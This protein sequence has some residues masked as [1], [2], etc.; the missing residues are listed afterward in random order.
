MPYYL[1]GHRAA[2][3]SSVVGHSPG[4]VI[5]LLLDGGDVDAEGGLERMSHVQVRPVDQ[6]TELSAGNVVPRREV[7]KDVLRECHGPGL[8]KPSPRLVLDRLHL[9]RR[10]DQVDTSLSVQKEQF[11]QPGVI[12][13]L[14]FECV[15]DLFENLLF[16]EC[17][18]HVEF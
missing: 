17:E 1:S 12:A 3:F 14:T 13:V 5:A 8:H 16:F 9:V 15:L 7:R 11:L 2:S 6:L 4:H 18:R 10:L